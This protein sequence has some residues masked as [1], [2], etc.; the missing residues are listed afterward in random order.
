[1][2]TILIS[3]TTAA[4]REPLPVSNMP[5]VLGA[6][7]AETH[8]CLVMN[9]PKSRGGPDRRPTRLRATGHSCHARRR[10]WVATAALIALGCIMMRKRKEHLPRGIATQDP[11]LRERFAGSLYVERLVTYPRIPRHPGEPRNAKRRRARRQGRPSETDMAVRFG[12]A[13]PD[14]RPSCRAPQAASRRAPAAS[15]AGSRSRRSARPRSSPS[16]H[17]ALE[18][19]EAVR[20]SPVE[21]TDRSI[22]TMLSHEITRLYGGRGFRRH[23]QDRLAPPAKA[24]ALS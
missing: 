8:Q 11:V 1:M 23:D 15:S 5:P 9:D 19:K 21:N 18:R 13:R 24:S 20:S 10:N 16:Q 3:A 12:R 2:P 6:G 17:P 14:L 22:A 7:L 4:G